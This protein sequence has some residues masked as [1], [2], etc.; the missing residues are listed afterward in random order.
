MRM[1]L[2]FRFIVDVMSQGLLALYFADLGKLRRYSIRSSMDAAKLMEELFDAKNPTIAQRA[3]TV[4]E[5]LSSDLQLKSDVLE[6]V[7]SEIAD[8]PAN[9][10][11]TQLPF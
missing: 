5:C 2:P 9:E 4:I 10:F 11:L 7:L 8:D 3:R 1:N 6:K